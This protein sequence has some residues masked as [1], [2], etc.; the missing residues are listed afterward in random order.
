[1]NLANASVLI[2]HTGTLR[3]NLVVAEFGS[4][5]SPDVRQALWYEYDDSASFR[6]WYGIVPSDSDKLRHDIFIIVLSTF[7]L[8]D[9]MSSDFRHG[10]S[11]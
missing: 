2:G 11:F 3:Y 9:S 7:V 4:Q 8:I 1:M 10:S 5:N 6:S